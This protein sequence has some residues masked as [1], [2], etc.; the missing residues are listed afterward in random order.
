MNKTSQA[1]ER[2]A[3]LQEGSL[4]FLRRNRGNR[5]A[6]S[7]EAVRFVCYTPCPAV[8]IITNRA[9]GRISIA[10]EEL[11]MAKFSSP[12]PHAPPAVRFLPSLF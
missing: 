9:G 1:P 12:N 3:T 8:V 6:P 4:Y 11:F 7:W 10:R 2:P 5:S